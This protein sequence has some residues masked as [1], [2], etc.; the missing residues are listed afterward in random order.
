MPH[1]LMFFLFIGGACLSMAFPTKTHVRTLGLLLAAFSLTEIA[2]QMQSLF[3]KISMLLSVGLFITGGI[4]L[5]IRDLKAKPVPV[6]NS[7][8]HRVK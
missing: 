3:I 2:A 6:K 7:K 4:V 1:E 5:Y 8:D